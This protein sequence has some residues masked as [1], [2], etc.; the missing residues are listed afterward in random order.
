MDIPGPPPDCVIGEGEE[1]IDVAGDELVC[2]WFEKRHW[3]R[4]SEFR[5]KYWSSESVPGGIVRWQMKRANTESWPYIWKLKS[6][7]RVG[8]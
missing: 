7:E 6:R 2:R 5:V 3:D 8:S 4:K 1:V